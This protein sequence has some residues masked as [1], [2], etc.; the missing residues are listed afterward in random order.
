MT[1][2]GQRAPVLGPDWVLGDDGLKHRDAARVIIL[3][4]NNKVLLVR[5]HDVDQ[6]ARTWWFTV[7][8]GID[9]GESSR[10]AAIRE[11]WEETGLRLESGSLVGPVIRRSAIFDFFAESC[12]QDEEFF[13]ARI[14]GAQD[15]LSREGWTDVEREVLDDVQ[16]W[17]LDDLAAVT[18]EVFPEGLG[19]VIRPLLNGWD[20]VVRDLGL[21][22]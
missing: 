8:G 20:G 12:R 16:W 10:E 6:P 9:P 1:D 4:E 14:G 11:V 15:G 13:L 2:P 22:V 18:V 21:G 7:G 5:G 17:D 3:D 19:E